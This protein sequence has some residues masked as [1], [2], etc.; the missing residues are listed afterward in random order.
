MSLW[1]RNGLVLASARDEPRP[2]DILLN[3]SLISE[4]GRQ[5]EPPPDVKILDASGHLIIPGLINAHVHGRENLLKGLVDN[6][7]LEAWLLQLA[8][9]SDDRTAEDQYVSVALG[10]IEMLKHGATSTYELFTHIPV[11]T[12]EAIAAVLQAYSDVGL[13]AIVAPSVADI[14][15]HRTIPGFTERLEPSLL[16]ALDD[17]FPLRDGHELLRTVEQAVTDWRTNTGESLVRIAI[18]PVIPERCS[19]GFLAACRDLAEAHALPLH[20]HL[21]ETKVQ[22]VERYR[23]DGCSTPTV[24][25][26]LGLL[27]PRTSLAHAIWV[28]DADIDLIAHRGCAVIHN[29][30]SNLKLGSGL[31]PMRKML[32]QR[33]HLAIGTDGC[34][35]ADHQNLFEAIRLAAYLHRPFEPDYEAWPRAT[36]MLEA[37]WEGGAHTLGLDGKLGRI[38]PG[39]L[40][41]LVLLDLDSEALTP[42]NHAANQLVMCEN[43]LSVR[44]VIVNGRIVFERGKPTLVD[45]EAIR[46]RARETARRLSRTNV[47]RARILSRAETSLRE[48]RLAALASPIPGLP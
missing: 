16:R 40:A 34:A 21:M 3:G 46:A 24:L 14:P 45:A 1:I 32:E 13:R 25:D 15:Y 12:P 39:Y 20:T 9:L 37:A 33:V 31:M 26:R 30:L 23:R 29:P 42:L 19:D 27:T 35:S 48:A 47:D 7:P 44:T 4:V 36:Q 38:T 41:D 2:L 43:G 8:A 18:A 5:L 28:T 6:R 10:A 17:L 22:A 11:M